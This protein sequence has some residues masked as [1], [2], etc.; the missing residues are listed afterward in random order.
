MRDLLIIFLLPILLVIFFG[1]CFTPATTQ[2]A[3]GRSLFP[4]ED[5]RQNHT[6]NLSLS[7]G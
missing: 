6:Q 7:Y 3:Y 1:Y 2:C 5:H 4:D